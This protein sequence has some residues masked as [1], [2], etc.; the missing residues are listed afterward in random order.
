MSVRQKAFP[1]AELLLLLTALIWGGGFIFTNLAI[2][3][4]L[5]LSLI[6]TLR[7]AIPAVMMAV[8]FRQE[9]AIATRRDFAC[10]AGAGVILFVA[11]FLQTYG[12]KYT[13]PA[14][15]AFLTATNVIMVPFISWLFFRQR[16]PISAFPLAFTCF[17]G[18]VVLAWTPGMG[19][20]FNVGDLLTLFCAFMFACHIAFLG[21]V[22]GITSSAAVLSV[23]QLGVSA[24]LSFLA[25]C[26]IDRASCSW[27]ALRE[28]MLPM[29]YLSLLS[30][31]L[32]YFLQNWAQRRVAPAKTAI[33]L[34]C[35][36][37]F[38]SLLSVLCGYDTP[39]V[40]FVVGGAIILLSV[41]L[42]Q[43]DWSFLRTKREPEAVS[44]PG[45]N[46][47]L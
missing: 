29:L 39:T 11:F 2:L 43:V 4:G 1:V 46:R 45:T 10:G 17:I 27:E 35:E 37:L 15:S 13:T 34:S 18:A 40:T 5:P 44:S 7:F 6:L 47:S 38:G 20:N 25:F 19:M 9:M 30:T 23:M 41:V 8:F 22:S 16:P 21:A 42:A 24:V 26:I 12:I 32:C 28:G 36:G 31:G 33:L 3:A 14:N